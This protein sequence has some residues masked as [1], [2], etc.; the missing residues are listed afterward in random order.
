MRP[1]HTVLL[2]V[3]LALGCETASQRPPVLPCPD[4]SSCAGANPSGGGGPGGGGG[5]DGGAAPTTDAASL[6]NVGGTV[7]VLDQL[8]PTATVSRVGAMG[9]TVRAVD[10]PDAATALTDANG[11]F[12]LTGVLPTFPDG[13]APV[14]GVRAVPT[15]RASIGV[16]REVRAGGGSVTFD[17]YSSQRVLEAVAAQGGAPS[18]D[19]GHIAVQITEATDP[20]VGVASAVVSPSTASTPFYDNDGSPG[21][22]TPSVAGTG[23][24]GFALVLNV[25][26]G[27]ESTGATVSLRISVP[28]ATP[29]PA[30]V[31]VRVFPNTLSWVAVR[32]AR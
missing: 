29:V 26:S 21:Q 12:T 9:W 28:G 5:S 4:G 24:R 8:P 30:E 32:V 19:L 1:N 14:I 18:A 13:G 17:S 7:V 16:Y 11:A 31:R 10:D 2:A 25:P 27:D 22:L 15:S 23:S 3:V 20:G 6:F